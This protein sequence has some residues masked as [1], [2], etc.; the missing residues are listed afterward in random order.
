VGSELEYGTLSIGTGRDDTDVGWVIDRN[1]DA[2]SENDF[3]PGGV[4]LVMT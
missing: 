3:L 2:C 1:N 4:Q